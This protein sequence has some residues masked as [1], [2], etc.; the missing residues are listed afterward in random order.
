MGDVFCAEKRSAPIAH[1][2]PRLATLNFTKSPCEPAKPP[3]SAPCTTAK[4]ARLNIHQK[5]TAKFI[6]NAHIFY[7]ATQKRVKQNAD[8]AALSNDTRCKTTK[9]FAKKVQT[10]N[11][12]FFA[13][14]L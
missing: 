13:V 11:K 4:Y 2:L 9:N 3:K 10:G 8:A 14:L 5:T 12:M 1:N 7:K 6:V